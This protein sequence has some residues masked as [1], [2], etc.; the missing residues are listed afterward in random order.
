MTCTRRPN[1]R[2]VRII[3]GTLALAAAV[4]RAEPAPPAHDIAPQDLAA[5]ARVLERYIADVLA[6]RI[7]PAARRWRSADV[8]SAARLGIRYPEAPLKV[9]GD[10]PLW[11]RVQDLRAGR[12]TCRTEPPQPFP[13]SGASPTATAAIVLQDGPDTLRFTYHFARED[14][15]WLLASPVALACGDGVGATSRFIRLVDRRTAP[16]T[17]AE[18]K[19]ML[20]ALDSCVSAAAAAL[21]LSADDLGR[22]ERGKFGYLL[23]DPDDVARLASAPT[24]GV[25]NLQQDCVV[26][27]HPCHAH[28]LAHL[29]VGAWL[30]DLPLYMLPLF[31]EGIAVHLGG[32]WGRQAR[33]LDRVGRTAL[34]EGWVALDDLLVGADFRSRPADQTYAPAGVFAGFLLETHGARGWRAACLAASGGGDSADPPDADSIRKDMARALATDWP[35]LRRAFDRYLM[36]PV[37]SG[38]RPGLDTRAP[39]AGRVLSGPR[40]TV[41]IFGADDAPEIGI[42]VRARAG[43]GLSGGAILFGGGDADAP[44]NALFSEHFP[45]RAYGG[46]TRALIFTKEEA[47]VYDYRLQMLVALHAEG[48]WPSPDYLDEGGTCLRFRVDGSA[49]PN[50]AMTLVEDRDE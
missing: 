28:E 49:W 8:A 32:R 43:A 21:D 27:S 38:V 3:A 44:A 36:T 31:Q 13:G 48:F 2:I 7:E 17:A 34:A 50:G 12:M 39:Q 25:A 47:K 14:G 26:T 15:R 33:I 42:S 29:V 37:G 35:S 1:S 19:L 16:A 23:A 40:L 46:E 11:L 10:S 4:A 18:A 9:D 22:L 30:Q 45:G 20:A 6:E 5:C 24:V 41:E